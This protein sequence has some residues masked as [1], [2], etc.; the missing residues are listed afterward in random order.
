MNTENQLRDALGTYVADRS[1][2]FAQWTFDAP[3][4]VSSETSDK[5]RAVGKILSKAISHVCERLTEEGVQGLPSFLPG[6]KRVFDIFNKRDEHHLGTY[7]TDF[8]LDQTKTPRLIEI[9]CRSALNGFFELAVFD[10]YAKTYSNQSDHTHDPVD[11]YDSFLPFLANKMGGTHCVCLIKRDGK[12]GSARHYK[13]IFEFAGFEVRDVHYSQIWD[14][15][16]FINNAFVIS[17]LDLESIVQLPD[18]ELELLASANLIN[19]FRTVLVAHDK[20][21]FSLLTNE[22]VLRPILSLNEWETIA[23][24]L[25]ETRLFDSSE[26]DLERLFNEQSDWVIKYPTLGDSQQ[27]YAGTEYQYDDWCS[28]L[29]DLDLNQFV[30]QRWIKQQTYHGTIDGKTYNDY[31]TGTLMYF[32]DSFFGFGPFRASSHCVNNKVDDR[33]MFPLI[34]RTSKKAVTTPNI[35]AF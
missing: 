14:N 30:L 12:G 32:D 31:V 1:E 26:G 20:R 18:R 25:V 28:L 10:K 5:M 23:P 35:L 4:L 13:S 6:T 3:I 15:R 22:T 29:G 2:Y 9:S 33:K 7:R 16:K 21:F 34:I 27:I 8:V 19:D 24:H 17:E 11:L